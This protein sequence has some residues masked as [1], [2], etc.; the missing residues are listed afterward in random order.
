[1]VLGFKD[2][3]KNKINEGQSYH[4]PGVKDSWDG[5]YIISPV[6]LTAGEKEIPSDKIIIPKKNETSIAICY[7]DSS[8]KESE[9]VWIPNDAISFKKDN[10]GAIIELDLDPYKKWISK[11]G[12]RSRIDDFIEDFA[13]H[14]E[15]SK[16]TGQDRTIQNAQDDVELLMDLIGIPGSIESFES[17]GDYMWEAKL[18]NGMLIEIT[19][20]SKDDL[21][22]KFKIYL[23]SSDHHPCVYINNDS[24]NKKTSFKIQDM[25]IITVPGGFTDVKNPD[26][27]VKYL[28]KRAMDI[29][30]NSDEESLLNHY[31]RSVDSESQDS[32]MLKN[33]ASLLSEFID[34]REVEEISSKLPKE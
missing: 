15:Y 16:T 4:I 11:E 12:N 3:Q 1:M 17:C 21:L 28:T 14:L 25:G 2:F 22:S 7:V 29:Q 19:K 10:N 32:E 20:R 34:K 31:K 30:D 18:D 23:N 24:L 5:G 6:D 33:V 27:Y 8:G 9:Y 13:N 26:P